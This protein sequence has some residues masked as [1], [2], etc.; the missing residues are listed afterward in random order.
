MNMARVRGTVVASRRSD[1]VEKPRFLL[2]ED[3]DQGGV[4]KGEYL[5]ALDLVGANRG[6]LVLCTQGSSC[7]QTQETEGKPMDALVVA[8]VQAMDQGGREVWKEA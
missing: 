6:Q 3:C 1:G 7:R 4:G 5:V 2:V 8:I